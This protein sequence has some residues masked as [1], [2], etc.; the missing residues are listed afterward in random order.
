M[1]FE[2][3]MNGVKGFWTKEARPYQLELARKVGDTYRKVYSKNYKP[4]VKI[5]NEPS[6]GRSGIRFHEVMYLHEDIYE[7]ALKE[8]TTLNHIIG[9]LTLCEG[10][11]GELREPHGCPKPKAKNC[12]GGKHGKV[13]Y[14]RLAVGEKHKVSTL[15]D[16]KKRNLK[17]LFLRNKVRKFTEDGG[18]EF[19]KGRHYKLGTHTWGDA[20]QQFDMMLYAWK[21]V[22][23]AGGRIIYGSFPVETVK[24][25]ED[26]RIMPDYSP[27]G[28]IVWDRFESIRDAW[29][30]IYG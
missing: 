24:F 27:G 28:G 3:N 20:Q 5:M 7:E 8:Y 12:R 6:H 15:P 14:N 19:G 26:G 23:S 29:E 18:T 21:Q 30:K 17:R 4:W 22:K 16:M 1:P 13:G 9:D 10:S 25:L 2:Q 11:L